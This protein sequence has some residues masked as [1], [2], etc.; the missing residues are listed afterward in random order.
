MAIQQGQITITGFLG[1][2]PTPLGMHDGAR[3]ACRFRLA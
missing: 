2:E 3:A 1:S